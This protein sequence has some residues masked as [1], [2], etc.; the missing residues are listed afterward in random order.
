MH[1]L[2]MG[3]SQHKVLTIVIHHGKSNQILMKLSEPRIHGKIIQ[4]IMH[5]TH[6]PFQVK[7]QGITIM[8]TGGLGDA[9]PLC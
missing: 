5:P 7:A 8:V 9:W 4:H 3:K 6:V 2:I 1:H